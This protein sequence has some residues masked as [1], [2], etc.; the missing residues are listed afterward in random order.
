MNGYIPTVL[1]NNGRAITQFDLPSRLLKDRIILLNDQVAD[2]TAY[3]INQQ[4]MYLDSIQV[5]DINLY[6]NS[7]GGS[8]YAGLSIYDT[9]KSLKSKVNTIA[10]GMAASMGAFLLSAG[11]GVRACTPEARIM[12]HSVSSGSRGTVHDMRLDLKESEFLND[13]LHAIMAEGTKGKF[14]KEQLLIE[15]ERDRWLSGTE[16]IEMG[17]IDKILGQ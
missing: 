7:P 4:L 1:E 3:A 6:I 17:L 9:I 2:V 13:R 12:I 15:T 11:T 5:G 10:T 8:V 16:A 14:T